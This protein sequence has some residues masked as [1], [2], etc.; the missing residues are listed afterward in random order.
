MDKQNIEIKINT[1]PSY[2]Y[3]KH[4]Y[5]WK[6]YR[7]VIE[8]FTTFHGEIYFDLF[9]PNDEFKRKRICLFPYA[10]IIITFGKI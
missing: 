2:M 4:R 6:F 9:L 7:L 8:R 5:K 10:I 1:N 3:L